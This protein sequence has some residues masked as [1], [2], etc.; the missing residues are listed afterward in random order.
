MGFVGQIDDR[1]GL[2]DSKDDRPVLRALRNRI[3]A[4][5]V[6]CKVAEKAD[7]LENWAVTVDATVTLNTR[8]VKELIKLARIGLEH[9]RDGDFE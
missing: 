5:E 2:L 7:T 8:R 1:M 9:G 6:A 4:L 3:D